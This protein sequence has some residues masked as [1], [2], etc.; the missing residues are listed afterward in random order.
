M[1]VFSPCLEIFFGSLPFTERMQSISSLGYTHYEFWSWWDKNL[2]AI[3]EKNEELEL[4]T[5][6]FCTRFV[7]LVDPN[8]QNAYLDGLAETIETA[9]KL[10]ANIIISQVGNELPDIPRSRQK[11]TLLAG[12]EKA[13]VLMKNTGLTLAI[14]PLNVLFDHP[15]YFLVHSQ[16][17]FEI[18][19]AVGSS[20]IQLLFDIYHQQISEG[21]LIPNIRKYVSGIAHFHMADHPGRHEPGTGEIHYGNVLQEIEKLNYKG[22]I[23]IE[24]FP[25]NNDH[26]QV[27]S[28]P[29]FFRFMKCNGG[30]H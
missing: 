26:R 22:T 4:T 8:L 24:L 13:A 10:K 12:L 16:E 9:K 6:A 21:N 29:L 18:V 17:A 3:A 7:S 30:M 2:N 25:L 23:G 15:G 11:D 1:L 28:D 19:S 27:L 20:D 14:E 5:Q